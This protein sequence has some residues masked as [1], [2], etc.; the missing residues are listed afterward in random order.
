MTMVGHGEETTVNKLPCVLGTLPGALPLS[1]NLI[2]TTIWIFRYKHF[3]L[4]TKKPEVWKDKMTYPYLPAIF[5]SP[6]IQT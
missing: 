6:E 3:Y 2:I 5:G 1:I 4:I